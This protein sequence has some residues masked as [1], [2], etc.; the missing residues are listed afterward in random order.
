MN[1]KQLLL[2]LFALGMTAIP[3]LA[4]SSHSSEAA[5]GIKADPDNK[6]IKGTVADETGPLIGATIKVAGTTNGTVTDFE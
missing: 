5:I 2:C 3:A 1:K 4:N 6:V